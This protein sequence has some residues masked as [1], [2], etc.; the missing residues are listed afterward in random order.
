VNRPRIVG[1]L[2]YWIIGLLEWYT[3]VVVDHDKRR[4]RLCNTPL[5]MKYDNYSCHRDIAI[6]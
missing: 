5:H 3:S 1:L 4:S 6:V 2:D